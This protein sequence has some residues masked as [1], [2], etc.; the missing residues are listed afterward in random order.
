[1]SKIEAGHRWKGL[2][3]IIRALSLTKVL[4]TCSFQ[5][6]SRKSNVFCYKT[7]TT[8]Q[9]CPRKQHKHKFQMFPFSC[10]YVVFC[11]HKESKQ[12]NCK[13]R[14]HFDPFTRIIAD[15]CIKLIF[16]MKITAFALVSLVKTKLLPRAA[17]NSSCDNWQQLSRV[18]SWEDQTIVC[19]P[20]TKVYNSLWQG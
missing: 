8:L 11:F 7:N 17:R 14:K 10:T 4:N 2:G 18:A 9:C 12:H 3:E 16:K 5:A 19:V 6:Y 13:K 20:L 1:M 15:A